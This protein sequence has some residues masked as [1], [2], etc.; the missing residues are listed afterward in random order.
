MRGQGAPLADVYI[1]ADICQNT[2]FFAYERFA[3][4]S[5]EEQKLVEGNLSLAYHA[6]QH[7][8]IPLDLL[9]DAKQVALEALAKSATSFDSSKGKFSTYAYKNMKWSLANFK[10][11]QYMHNYCCLDVDVRRGRYAELG[12]SRI[13]LQ[14]TASKDDGGVDRHLPYETFQDGFC[15]MLQK[16]C[17]EEMFSLLT[18]L[19]QKLAEGDSV[20]YKRYV[21]IIESKMGVNPKSFSNLGAEW[22]VSKQRVS[23]MWVSLKRAIIN[24][25]PE[26]K[27]Y[28]FNH[29]Y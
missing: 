15:T 27:N 10:H 8:R 29:S 9:E 17:G 22:G 25:A 4:L 18:P 3:M 12:G 13:P 24:N 19:I 5:E 21:Q 20:K 26:L 23:Q 1:C 2:K 7:S 28:L 14:I 6:A 11:K 16:E